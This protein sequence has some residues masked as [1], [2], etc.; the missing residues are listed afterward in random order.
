MYTKQLF[1]LIFSIISFNLKGQTTQEFRFEIDWK[2]LS[3]A[4]PTLKFAENAISLD[5]TPDIS[6]FFHSIPFENVEILSATIIEEEVAAV[7]VNEGMTKGLGSTYLLNANVNEIRRKYN[8]SLTVIP[9]KKISGTQVEILKKFRVK[10]EYVQNPSAGNRNPDATY[11][12]VLS[13]GDIYKISVNQTGLYKIDKAFLENKLGINLA[14]LN[15]KKIKLYGNKGGRVPEAN[16][17]KRIDDLEQLHIFVSGE[18]DGK[19]DNNDYILFYAEGPDLWSYNQTT[20]KYSFDKNIYD[21]FN[22]FF[23]KIDNEDGLRISK[24]PIVN[25]TP[26]NTYEEYDFLQRLEEDKTNLLGSYTAAEGTG[27]QWYG[28]VF[29]SSLR[30]RNYTSRFDFSGFVNT[31]PLELEMVFAGRS[32]VNNSVNVKIGSKSINRNMSAVSDLN[33]ESLYARRVTITDN[34]IIPESNPEVRVNYP[35]VSAE[36]QGWLD[37]IQIVNQRKINLPTSGQLSFRN[38]E[39]KTTT[40]SAFRL[41]GYTNQVVWDISNPFIPQEMTVNNSSIVFNTQGNNREFLAHNQLNGAFEPIGLGK[42]KNQNIHAMKDEDMIIVCFP[43]FK[44]QAQILADHR[45]KKSNIKVLVVE[46]TE[47]YN[48]FGGGKADPAAIRDMARLL[49]FRNPKFKYLLLFGDGSFD[50]K[51]IIKDM[52]YENFVP[53]YETDESLDPIDG[54][55]SDDF[56]GLLGD[57]EGVNL[58]GGLDIYVGRLPARNKDQAKILT[59]KIIHYETNPAT[60]GDWRIRTSYVADDEDRNTHLSDIDDIARIDEDR[61]PIY[62]QQKVYSDAFRQVSTSGEKRYPDATRAIND[63]MFKGQISMTYLGHGGPLGWAQERIL[64]VP[65]IQNWTNYNSMTLLVTATCSFG[66]YDDP[67]IVSPAEHAILNPKG[68]AIALMTT[69]RAVYTNSNKQLTDAAHELMYKKVNGN[70]PTLGYILS[71]GKNKYANEFFRINSRKFA[72]LGDP[73]MQIAMP[74]LDVIVEKINNK[75]AATFGDT[76]TALKKV[77]MDGF[78]SNESG[79]IATDFNGTV[80]LTVFDKKSNLQTL[81][82]DGDAS[83]RFSYSMYKNILF[84][85]AAT[86]SSGKWTISFWIPKNINYSLGYGRL[87]FYATDGKEKDAAGLYNR[88][89]IGGSSNQLVDNQGPLIQGYMN[90][91]NF[92]S[93]GMTN[94]NPVLLLNLSDDFGINVTGNAIGQDITAVLDGD[95]KNTFILNDFY[96]SKK[97]DFS[98]GKVKFP[99]SGLSKGSHYITAKAWDISGNSAETRIDFVVAEDK[100]STISRVYNYPN[101]FTTFTQFQFEHDLIN[102]EIDIVVN[103]YT[104]TGKLIKSITQ[105]KYSSGFRVNDIGWNGNDDFD[106]GLARGIY[107]YKIHIHSKSLNQSRESKFEKLIKL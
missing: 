103:I 31:R 73:S 61:H 16:N 68:G 12:S 88:L 32:R 90:D 41:S 2:D 59:D 29:N 14:N 96:E 86:V 57:T 66:A 80:F 54:F 84:K 20:D 102:T 27:K 38:R 104:I 13:A 89:Y 65:D 100:N 107:L 36:S 67:S 43:D 18:A 95:N 3:G 37:Y 99:L 97:D 24:S 10:I 34:F 39:S 35:N 56:Y 92:V 46:T 83:P 48:E 74:K 7:N 6:G 21:D 44:A 64:T 22:Y 72:L 42:V 87:S 28:D 9:A 93:G 69:T 51:G 23:I 40:N 94:A 49:L 101:P 77:T 78:I 106:S 85:G 33:Q 15:P 75:E 91:D 76:I 55:P 63:N 70:A 52:P 62:N 1:L 79:N 105:T 8:L 25:S 19:F 58:V 53:V 47:V 71:E 45:Q 50:Y 98:S 60:L 30:E 11:T 82:N 26:Q 17:V 5:A 4:S 81:S